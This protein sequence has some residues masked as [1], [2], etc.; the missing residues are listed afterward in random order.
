MS[1]LQRTDERAPAMPAWEYAAAPESKDI[2]R[3]QDR[4]GLFIGG[5]FVDPMSGRTS[6]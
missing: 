6:A 1:E 3:L 2:V 4:Y 5:E